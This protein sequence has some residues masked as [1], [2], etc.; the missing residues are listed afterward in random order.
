MMGT[1]TPGAPANELKENYY[2]YT[3]HKLI[4][5]NVSEASSVTC[6]Y[7]RKTTLKNEAFCILKTAG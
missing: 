7:R 5:F 2:V 1:P 6:V 4:K 3:E